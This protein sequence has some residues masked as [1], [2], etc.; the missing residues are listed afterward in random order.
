[1]PNNTIPDEKKAAIVAL[2]S[3][4]GNNAISSKLGISVN[5]VRKYKQLAEENGTIEME[6]ADL[7]T[8]C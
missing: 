1:M 2:S 8:S 3:K 4:Y 6:G 5:T 7:K